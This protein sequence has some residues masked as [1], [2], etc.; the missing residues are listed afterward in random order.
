[1]AES[2][3]QARWLLPLS[4][5]VSQKALPLL[6]CLGLHTVSMQ[7]DKVSWLPPASN[8]QFF[9][10]KVNNLESTGATD[11]TRQVHT[12]S[13]STSVAPNTSKRACVACVASLPALIASL[14]S[15]GDSCDW[16]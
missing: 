9:E 11:V 13:G 1:M 2:D 12:S 15:S 6:L 10:K 14:R 7:L 5:I 16:R 4:E 8:N 3:A